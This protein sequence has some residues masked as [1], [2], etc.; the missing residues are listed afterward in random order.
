M[1]LHETTEISLYETIEIRFHLNVK[2][3]DYITTLQI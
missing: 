1:F 3:I 2:E